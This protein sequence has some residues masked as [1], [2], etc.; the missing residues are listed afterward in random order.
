MDKYG[1]GRTRLY[2]I[3]RA[4]LDRRRG[5]MPAVLNHMEGAVAQAQGAIDTIKHEIAWMDE[6][7]REPDCAD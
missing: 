4:E 1:L 2:E 6:Q 3:Y 5:P 7:I